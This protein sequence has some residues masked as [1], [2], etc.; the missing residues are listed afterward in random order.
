MNI[1]EE[2]IVTF[3]QESPSLHQF[4]SLQR[5]SGLEV[6]HGKTLKSASHCLQVSSISFEVVD[7]DTFHFYYVILD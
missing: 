2:S 7:T 3:F 1:P 6:E 4:N 5:T